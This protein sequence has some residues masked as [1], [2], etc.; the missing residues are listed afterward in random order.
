[1]KRPGLTEAMRRTIECPRHAA[2]GIRSKAI[3]AGFITMERDDDD[4][5]NYV[6]YPITPRGQAALAAPRVT[7]AEYELLARIRQGLRHLQGA[8]YRT[9]KSMRE[10]GWVCTGRLSADPELTDAG[11]T[12]LNNVRAASGSPEWKP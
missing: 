11:T 1:M 5:S 10:K 9:F 3:A 6:G 2:N 8:E 4:P 7:A 12:A